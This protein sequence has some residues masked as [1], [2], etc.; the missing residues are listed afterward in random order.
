MEHRDVCG[1]AHTEGDEA[2]GLLGARSGSHRRAVP[3]QVGYVQ[4]VLPL[5]HG[6]GL[7]VQGGEPEVLGSQDLGVEIEPAAV[8]GPRHVTQRVSEL[9]GH[10][11]HV[12]APGVHHV[13]LVLPVGIPGPLVALEGDEA[14]VRRRH[15][16]LVGARDVCELAHLPRLHVYRI[17]L[18]V[19]HFVL[20]VFHPQSAEDQGPTVGHPPEIAVVVA[21]GGN[22][23]D[24]ASLGPHHEQVLV[25]PGQPTHPIRLVGKPVLHPGLAGP[26]RPLG[27]LRHGDPPGRIHGLRH[28]HLKG[29]PV[30]LRR[31]LYA[32]GPLRETRHLAH[33]SLVVHPPDEDLGPA[34]PVRGQVGDPGAVR[35]PHRRRAP[36]ELP[37][38]ASVHPHDP[39]GGVHPVVH[40][41]HPSPR[42]QDLPAVGRELG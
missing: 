26:A 9:P 36:E 41:V 2:P 21:S 25:A 13:Q 16:I 35:G 17:D 37:V 15:G 29:E 1:P 28:E 4:H 8:R 20:G 18:P 42:V 32:G 19:P 12:S 40:L 6:P 5:R 11:A 38:P 14:P 3:A 22:L 10:P 27:P 7:T 24:R 34:V 33:G 23:P 31:P 39:D 30:P